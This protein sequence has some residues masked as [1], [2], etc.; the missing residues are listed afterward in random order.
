MHH[1]AALFEFDRLIA[2]L[3]EYH[4]EYMAPFSDF[5]YLKQA[6]SVAQRW[7][8]DASRIK[9]LLDEKRISTKQADNFLQYGSVGR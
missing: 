3:S 1:L 8:V 5:S 4:V 7:Q 9:K 2:N 6:F